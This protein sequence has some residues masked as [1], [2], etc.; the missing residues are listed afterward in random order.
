MT[1][2]F[3]MPLLDETGTTVAIEGE[4]RTQATMNI[5]LFRRA[6]SNLLQ[7]AI[8]HSVAGAH[9]VVTITQ[10]AGAIW[11]AVAN[12]GAPIASACAWRSPRCFE[13]RHRLTSGGR[14]CPRF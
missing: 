6:L 7:N 11:I 13:I 1:I 10:R 14:V 3:F 9:L 12:P 5:A 8:E 4:S 2:E